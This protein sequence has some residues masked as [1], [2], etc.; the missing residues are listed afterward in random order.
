MTHSPEQ[1]LKTVFPSLLHAARYAALIQSRVQSLE[2]KQDAKNIFQAALSDADVT[3]QAQIEVVLLAN[4]PEIPFFGEEYKSSRNTRYLSG[5]WFKEGCDYLIT[6]DPIDGTRPYIDGHKRYQI[7]LTVCSRDAF[8][9]VLFVY[10]ATKTYTYAVRDKGI[11]HGTFD[12][13]FEQALRLKIPQYKNCVYVAGEYASLNDKFAESFDRVYSVVNYTKESS[14]PYFAHILQGEICGGIIESAQV[15]DGA[16]FA[17]AAH[18]LGCIVETLDGKP[19][20]RPGEHPELVLPGLIVGAT[21]SIV[22]NI[23][24]IL[25][26]GYD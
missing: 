7:I 6:L 4:F 2:E 3:I 26:T 17:F 18:E 16:A 1:I 10:P 20:P 22:K 9:A 15:I 11:F 21:R 14:T 5:T 8:E 23:R 24:T 13:P 12:T 25:T 19:F